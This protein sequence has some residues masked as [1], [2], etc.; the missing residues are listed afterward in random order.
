MSTSVPDLQSNNTASKIS[1][2]LGESEQSVE[3]LLK[4]GRLAGTLIATLRDKGVEVTPAVKNSVQ[5]MVRSLEPKE[6]MP[7][8]GDALGPGSDSSITSTIMFT[9]LVGSSAIMERLGDRG[10]R[11]LLRIHDGII[12]ERTEAYGGSP[13]KSTGDGFMLTFPSARSAVACAIEVQKSFE[14][15]DRENIGEKL[16]VRIGVSVGEPIYDN[17]DLFGRSVIVAARIV[18]IAQGG[19]ILICSIAHALVSSVG[20]FR[21]KLLDEVELKGITGRQTIHQVIW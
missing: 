18:E 14:D 17:R 3:E 10:G 12:R 9:D 6:A 4:H 7:G 8:S 13:I 2:F 15:Y 16:S 20:D 5:R 1:S 11:R 21:T 19:Q